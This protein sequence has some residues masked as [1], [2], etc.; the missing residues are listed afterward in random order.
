MENLGIERGRQERHV[1][2]MTPNRSQMPS[3]AATLLQI[4]IA[5]SIGGFVGYSMLEDGENQSTAIFGALVAGFGGTWLLNF[6]YVWIR[7]G[8]KAAR[9]MRMYGND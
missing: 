8:W 2:D 1:V 9:S 6:I 5:S 3:L 4:A 7:Y